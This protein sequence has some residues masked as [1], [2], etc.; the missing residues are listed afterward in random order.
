[1]ANE[2][3][4]T[5]VNTATDVLSASISRALVNKVVC[6]PHVFAEDLPFGTKTKLA[7]KD[8]ATGLGVVR[9]EAQAYTFDVEGEFNQSTVS[10]TA[11]KTV[12]GSKLVDEV[13]Q[14]TPINSG[15]IVTEHANSLART[16]DNNVKALAPGFSQSVDAGAAGTIEAAMEAAF[17]ISAGN[18]A[19]DGGSLVGIF[20]HKYIYQIRKQ[21]VQ[22]GAVAWSNME[23]LSLLTTMESPNGYAGSI[24]GI[25]FYQVQGMPTGGGKRSGMVFNPSLAFF[26]MYSP[27]PKVWLIQKGSEGVYTEVISWV[28]SQVAEWNDAA[29]VEVEADE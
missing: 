2:I 16:L 4:T 12:I 27:S 8:A 5:T 14:F 10:L 11:A 6:L 22:T 7:Q 9:A 13:E 28:Y 15:R 23:M 20:D 18:A 3:L 1:M 19:D 17:L 21:L 24:P 25:D 29:G 26:G